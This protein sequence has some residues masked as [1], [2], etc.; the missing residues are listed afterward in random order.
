MGACGPS[1]LGALRYYRIAER[2]PWLMP[3]PPEAASRVW[4]FHTKEFYML[5]K[6]AAA[7]GASAIARAV[8]E[9]LEERQ[10]LT[11][12][13][14]NPPLFLDIT[15][16]SSDDVIVLSLDADN[17][18]TLVIS[19]NGVDTMFDLATVANPRVRILGDAGADLLQIDERNGRI[20]VSFFID[21]GDGDDTLIGGS[22]NDL[23]FGDNGVDQLFGMSGSDRLDG[24]GDD[25]TVNGGAGNDKLYGGDGSDSLIGASGNDQLFGGADD[26]IL[27][28]GTGDDYLA[29]NDGF[30][31]LLGGDGND[32][33][34]GGNDDDELD[35]GKG[36][37]FLFGE[38][39]DDTLLGGLG[40][41]Q[42]FGS[43][44]DDD[45]EGGAGNDSLDGGDGID[46]LFGDAGADRFSLRRGDTR[47]ELFDFNPDEGDTLGTF[48]NNVN[49]IR[50][51]R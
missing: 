19:D 48:K 22:G 7:P 2:R 11:V 41:D 12:T 40:H 5:R 18:N 8:M 49:K 38:A 21:G 50:F 15:G 35:G 32:T 17:K 27:I 39:G 14:S 20:R 34:Y 30:D 47:G 25:D 51:G 13:I 1:V 16:T 23:L 46:S 31:S 33:L 9:T 29:G 10:F 28:G 4:A 43:L 24:G 3:A 37:D 6:H 26:D 36:G 45:L 42:L 44:G